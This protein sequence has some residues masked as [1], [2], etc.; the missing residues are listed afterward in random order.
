V[1]S[2]LTVKLLRPLT[3][4]ILSHKTLGPV[5]QKL[6][7]REILTY[8]A[9]GVVTT[10][11]AFL[12]FELFI[13]AGVGIVSTNVASSLIAIVFAFAINKHFVFL[14]RDWS[15]GNTAPELVKFSGGRLVVMFAE[16]G[17]LHLLVDIWGFN[18]TI[19]KIFTL[20]MVVVV[21]YII[22]KLIF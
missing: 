5:A 3:E 12:L 2:I 8:L 13:F 18:D 20:V 4:K 14:S 7:S 10:I 17:L 1:S 21:N 16:T 9:A 19:C 15:F 22:S 6:L 11:F